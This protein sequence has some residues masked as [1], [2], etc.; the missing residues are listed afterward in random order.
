MVVLVRDQEKIIFL[1]ALRRCNSHW[2]SAYIFFERSLFGKHFQS[3][4]QKNPDLV[5]APPK[6]T[7]NT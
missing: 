2:L 7:K 5:R 6:V 3:A 4:E 1:K